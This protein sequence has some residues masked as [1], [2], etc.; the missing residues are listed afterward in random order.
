MRGSGDRAGQ[1]NHTAPPE[2]QKREVLARE[3]T[4][5][6]AGK[7]KKTVQTPHHSNKD[8][9]ASGADAGETQDEPGGQSEQLERSVPREGPRYVP[10]GHGAGDE[11]AASQ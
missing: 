11:T 9:Q 1:Y 8:A 2:T 5:S 7:T 6:G 10:P 3:T 4:V